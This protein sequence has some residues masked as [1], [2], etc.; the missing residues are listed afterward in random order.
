MHKDLRYRVAQRKL[1]DSDQFISIPDHNPTLKDGTKDYRCC[2]YDGSSLLRSIPLPKPQGMFLLRDADGNYIGDPEPGE[3]YV[4]GWKDKE[5][6]G[7]PNPESLIYSTPDYRAQKFSYE[8][9]RKL[10][11]RTPTLTILES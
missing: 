4:K 5:R 11:R 6:L 3:F 8:Q 1:R 9:A 2:F 7:A 10:Q